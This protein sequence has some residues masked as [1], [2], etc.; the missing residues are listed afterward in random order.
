[1]LHFG[2]KTDLLYLRIKPTRVLQFSLASKPPYCIL[3]SILPPPVLYFDV[4]SPLHYFL[5][6]ILYCIL[7]LILYCILRDMCTSTHMLLLLLLLSPLLQRGE[8]VAVGKSI[9]MLYRLCPSSI[10][11]QS[12]CIRIMLMVWGCGS[13][14][15][16]GSS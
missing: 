9:S 2:N 15:S 13:R 5:H 1:M 8:L 16:A 3:Y 14:K 6:F 7:Y 11:Q 10:S 4:P 12:S